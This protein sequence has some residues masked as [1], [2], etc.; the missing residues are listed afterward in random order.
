M[1]F[2]KY[3]PKTMVPYRMSIKYT[4]ECGATYP[5]KT[6]AKFCSNCGATVYDKIQELEKQYRDTQL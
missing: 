2:E 5:L 6:E 3:K 1:D 4:C